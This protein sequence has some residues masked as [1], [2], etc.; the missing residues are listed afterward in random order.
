[1]RCSRST[2]SSLVLRASRSRRRSASLSLTSRSPLRTRA[3]SMKS[4]DRD[5]AVHLGLQLHAFLSEQRPRRRHGLRKRR[6]QQDFGGHQHRLRPRRCA[7]GAE[8]AAAD[9][10]SRAAEC[11]PS[12]RPSAA[13]DQ[14]L[15]AAGSKADREYALTRATSNTRTS[16]GLIEFVLLLMATV[17]PGATD[18]GRMRRPHPYA[19]RAAAAVPDRISTA[20]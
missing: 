13:L 16:S 7:A 11:C 5:L 8:T 9:G 1:M 15:G 3:P 10:G 19:T 20:A 12:R 17:R 14:S 4:I 2:A 6:G 18:E